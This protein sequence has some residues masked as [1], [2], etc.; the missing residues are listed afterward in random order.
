MPLA[1]LVCLQKLYKRMGWAVHLQLLL[2][3][4]HGQSLKVVLFTKSENRERR[5]IMAVFVETI[6][7]EGNSAG[8]DFES[9]SEFSLYLNL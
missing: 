9:L 5:I 1:H 6:A 3:T 7:E 2:T 8:R 4:H